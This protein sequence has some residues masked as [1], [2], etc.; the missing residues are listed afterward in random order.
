LMVIIGAFAG[1]FIPLE[2]LDDDDDDG[3]D[4]D[5]VDVDVCVPGEL[6]DGVDPELHAVRMAASNAADPSS[7]ERFIVISPL[8]SIRE[9]R[10]RSRRR[11]R[12]VSRAARRIVAAVE[13]H[14]PAGCRC[15]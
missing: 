13:S 14:R 11:S 3:D 2:D 9:C 8:S 7:D 1:I 5:A 12:F 15:P 6:L 10:K 4:D